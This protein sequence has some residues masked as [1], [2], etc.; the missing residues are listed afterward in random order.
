[1]Y[2]VVFFI[3][4]FG[5]KVKEFG[6]NF[7]WDF[8][9]LSKSSLIVYLHPTQCIDCSLIWLCSHESR[10]QRFYNNYY[11]ECVLLISIKWG[12]FNASEL[13][14][15]HEHPGFLI[16]KLTFSHHDKY[17]VDKVGTK[18]YCCFYFRGITLR[19]AHIR[20]RQE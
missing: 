5:N 3:L 20:V 15:E 18:I 8:S 2:T 17:S 16:S 19:W 10:S 6:S 14:N 13:L 7:N 9:F 4:L 11:W 12:I 1:M